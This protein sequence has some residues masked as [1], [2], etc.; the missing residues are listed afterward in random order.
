MK[1]CFCTWT[2]ATLD[3]TMISLYFILVP[4]LAHSFIHT[5]DYFEYFLGAPI[6]LGEEVFTIHHIGRHK[7]LEMVDDLALSAYD[8]FNACTIPHLW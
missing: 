6:Y 8:K 3:P 2:L 1:G 5:N 7:V 4:H